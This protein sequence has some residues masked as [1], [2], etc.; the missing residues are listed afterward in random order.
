MSSASLSELLDWLAVAGPSV[1]EWR[2]WRYLPVTGGANNRIVRVTSASQDLAIKWTIRDA[3]DRAG[4]EY[5]ALAALRDAGLTIAPEPILLD[6]DHYPQPVMVATWLAAGLRV[7]EVP[8][9][10]D[11]REGGRSKVGWRDALRGFTGAWE[12][13]RDARAGRY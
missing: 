12:V 2:G 13:I 5:H 7:D 1:G 8:T 10:Y 9:H 3:R 4:R 6:R 11:E